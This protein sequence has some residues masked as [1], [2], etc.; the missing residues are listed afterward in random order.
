MRNAKTPLPAEPPPSRSLPWAERWDGVIVLGLALLVRTIYLLQIRSGDPFYDFT[1]SGW[2]QHTY[3][4][5]AR[6]IVAG[7]WLLTNWGLFYYNPLYSYF[8]AVVYRIF[9]LNNFDALHC[10]QAL[11]GSATC[12]MLWSFA[13]RHVERGEALLAAVLAVFFV[14]W[15]FYEQLLLVEVLVVFLSMAALWALSGAQPQLR[16]GWLRLA[17]AGVAAGVSYMGRGSFALVV[18]GLAGWVIYVWRRA[19]SEG[20]ER[21][22]RNKRAAAA[23][24]LFLGVAF[25]TLLPLAWRNHHVAGRWMFGTTNGPAMLYLGNAADSTGEFFYS[26]RFMEA[27][28]EAKVDPDAYRNFMLEDLRTEPASIALN[29]ARKF[30]YF[31]NASDIADNTSLHVAK[32]FSALMRFVPFGA[33]ALFTL[34]LLGAFVSIPRWRRDSLL[35]VFLLAF[36]ISIILVVPIGRYRLPVFIPLLVFASRLPSWFVARGRAG[37]IVPVVAALVGLAAIAFATRPYA[38]HRARLQDYQT[39]AGAAM[40]RGKLRSAERVVKSGNDDYPSAA[41]IVLLDFRLSVLTEDWARA[42]GLRDAILNSGV[43]LTFSTALP[44]A[45]SYIHDGDDL[46]ADQI[47]AGILKANPDN[48]EARKLRES[49]KRAD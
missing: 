6:E 18:L 2:D 43:K 34:G 9:G 1:L 40:D 38:E 47:L 13:R 29:S 21:Q 4:R 12:W 27:F 5:Q 48:A 3:Q 32:N 36:S 41:V 16:F 17:A 25:I 39:F 8:C 14:P 45:R 26:D 19:Q 28:E 35:W 15:F 33:H 23:V 31:W 46:K 11:M 7:D 24:A 22:L 37:K 44:M 10:I 30:R 42:R 49:L 20:E